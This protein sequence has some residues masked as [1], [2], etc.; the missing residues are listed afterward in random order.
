MTRSHARSKQLVLPETPHADGKQEINRLYES[1][2]ELHLKIPGGTWW[3]MEISIEIERFPRATALAVARNTTT[4]VLDL[5]E[6]AIPRQN[7][8][9]Q[10]KGKT[11]NQNKD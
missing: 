6:N 9:L 4:H 7:Q 2:S 10:N 8:N 5:H 1:F 3:E 11:Q